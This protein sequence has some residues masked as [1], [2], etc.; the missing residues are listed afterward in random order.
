MAERQSRFSLS[1]TQF[2]RRQKRRPR[3][4][5]LASIHLLVAAALALALA[6]ATILYAIKL[7]YS[8]TH[9]ANLD[10]KVIS[11]QHLPPAQNDQNRK[12][13]E[14]RIIQDDRVA[15]ETDMNKLRSISSS[16]GS[17]FFGP[18]SH[19]VQI[20]KND[21]VDLSAS[22]SP[23]QRELLDDDSDIINVEKER[24]R[25][26]SYGFELPSNAKMPLRRRRLFYG[27]LISAD[28]EEVIKATSMEQYNIFHTV[29]LI[30]SNSTQNLTPKQWRFFGSEDA[31]KELNWLYQLFGP[32]TKVSVDYYVTSLNKAQIKNFYELLTENLQREGN[33][34]RWKFNGMRPDDV[35]IVG[36]IDETFSR[37]FLRALQICDVPQFRPGQSCRSPKVS[38]STLM[39]EA[40][41]ECSWNAVKNWMGRNA[42]GRRWYHPDAMLGECVDQIGD[43]ELHPPTKRVYLGSHGS[44]KDFYGHDNEFSFYDSNILV[45]LNMK[46]Q[47]PLWFPHDIRQEN[48]MGK[49]VT[50]KDMW[51]SPT[52]Y[53]FHNFFESG[54]EIRFKYATYG[55]ADSKALGQPR[56]R[57]VHRA[58]DMAVNC[59]L[60][61]HTKKAEISFESIP[62]S[63]RPIY[64]LNEE[65]R[66]ARHSV[67]QD[68]V[69]RDE[70]K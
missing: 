54:E 44:R 1:Q 43:T 61:K 17:F 31:S 15:P 64:Y 60:G 6:I 25:C 18:D 23:L 24:E 69:R 29:S 19:Q 7:Y 52:G 22:W 56:L 50:K 62:S 38:A 59:A 32:K 3:Q 11:S 28:T 36:D 67:W 13:E 21:V 10:D 8:R 9:V 66:K 49:S 20:P 5:K 53:H 2:S 27:A 55:H 48:F 16:H 4:K 41:P 46:G 70:E 42:E 34:Y 30:E 51:K 14:Q 37:D 12:K 65:A 45:D 33:L 68:I 26:A 40:S 39:F 47:G 57:G 58:L 63:S 35:A